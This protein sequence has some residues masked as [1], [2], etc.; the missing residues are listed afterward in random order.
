MSISIPAIVDTQLT[1]LRNSLNPVYHSDTHTY[2]SSVPPYAKG[3]RAADVLR[4]LTGLIDASSLTAT[5]GTA[6]SVSKT[7]AFTGV[8][9][10]IGAKVT[11]SHTTTTVALRDVSAYVIG[12]TADTLNFAGGALPDT[13]VNGDV[14]SVE[15]TTVDSD[16]IV[17]ESGKEFG[18]SQ[19]NPFGAGPSL[20]NAIMK[21]V[22]QLGG[23]LPSYLDIHSAEPFHLGSPHAGAGAQG[24]GGA[25]LLADALQL[26][27]DT[28]AAYT[29]PA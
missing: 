4:M 11:F 2:T 6:K 21:L 24:Q 9:S 27:R 20:I 17:L 3:N 28:V 29:K 14:F 26:V 7:G 18:G 13:P 1:A 16:L 5:G 23:A 12:N 19:S 8:N 22:V 10:L 25:I 15:Y